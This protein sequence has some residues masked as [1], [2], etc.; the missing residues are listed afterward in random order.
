MKE[1]SKRF[2]T[3]LLTLAVIFAFTPFV[4]SMTGDINSYG[5]TNIYNALVMSPVSCDF[6]KF[7]DVTGQQV[8]QERSK[9]IT[10]KNNG[11]V[12]FT[13]EIVPNSDIHYLP[14]TGKL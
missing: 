7:T 8:L 6:G 10:I 13:V 4:G 3:V 2:V 5:E 9:T 1:I 14:Y 12:P 11:G